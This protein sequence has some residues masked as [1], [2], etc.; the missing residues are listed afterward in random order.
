MQDKITSAVV[1]F[2]VLLFVYAKF[3]PAVPF[4]VTQVTT[5]KPEPFS[6]SA[7]GKVTVVP[8]I[9]QVSL[10]F[11]VIESSVSQAQ[12]KAN[13]V[14]NNIS[15]AIKKL[16][17]DSKDIQTSNYNL[18]PEY[19]NSSK[20]PK[21]TGYSVNV[22]LYVNVRDFNKIN[23][24]IDA[25]TENGANQVDSLHF[26]LDDMEKYRSEARKNAID[27]AKK[28]ATEIA[29]QSGISLGK[30]INVQEGDQ[31]DYLRTKSFDMTAVP[32][33]GGSTP[34]QV[35]AGS[36]EVSVSV[37]LQYETR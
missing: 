9:A 37:T 1:V 2:F 7:S 29:Q 14:I 12:D 21:L 17:V 34:T 23:Q 3:G 30:L 8:N 32:N 36:S 16:G 5:T 19:D 18:R 15:S 4:A 33:A 25:A 20:P 28:K 10:G 31:G 35:E 24:V 27:N 13:K 6:V 22:S 26:T 11:N